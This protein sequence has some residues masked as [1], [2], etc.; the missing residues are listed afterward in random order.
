MDDGQQVK[1]G[2]LTLCTDSYSTNEVNILRE[3]LKKNF[4]LETTIHTKKGKGEAVYERIYLKKEEFEA[5]KPEIVPHMHDSMLYK[6][7]E[8]I[9]IK[10]DSSDIESDSSEM[11]DIFDIG[12]S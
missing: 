10:Q 3:A 5:L 2:G 6:I 12:G 1:R 4:N 11:M 8:Q 7:N 9:T